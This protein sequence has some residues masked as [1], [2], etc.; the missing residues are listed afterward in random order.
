MTPNAYMA[1]VDFKSAY[2]AVSIHKPHRKYFR[3]YFD[4]I[5]YQ[6]TCL[7]MGLCTGPRD[8]TNIMKMLFKFL[9]S[10]GHL[11]TFYI[12]DSFLIHKSFTGCLQNV[13][14]TVQLST[15][16]GFTVHPEK[17]VFR[18]T[19]QLSYLGF[20]LNTEFMTVQ[21]DDRKRCKII[22][23]IT[24]VL[25]KTRPV[26]QEVAELTGQLVATF[27]AVPFGRLFYRQ[28]DI[29]KAKALKNACGN[30]NSKM[31]L[32]SEAKSDL[33][34]WLKNI[35]TSITKIERLNP[36]FTMSSDASA[37]GYGAVLNTHTFSGQWS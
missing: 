8:F 15:E 25:S 23:K 26:I 14:D 6:F 31:T 20:V 16:A 33:K 30:F 9:R 2:Y 1:S 34:W 11:N 10:K 22:H 37:S 28:V 5:K 4:S 24:S 35:P 12:D 19:K 13:I 18:P 29:D 7:P 21:L 3:F 27:P 17:S 36:D 32:S